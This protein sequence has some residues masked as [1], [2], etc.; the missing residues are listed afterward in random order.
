MKKNT[1]LPGQFLFDGSTR[2][3]K[4][5]DEAVESVRMVH[6]MLK[7][8]KIYGCFSGGKDSLAMKIVIRKAAEK[9]GVPLSEY[10]DFHYNITGIDPPELYRYIKQSHPDVQMHMYEESM[11]SLIARK[12]PPTR[13]H[14][15]CCAHLKERGGYGRYC[16]TG[17]RWEESNNRAK[18]RAR[19]ETLGKSKR[20]N[21]LFND[22]GEARRNFEMC[23]IKAKRIVNPIIGFTGEDVWSLIKSEREPYCCLY[24]EGFDRLGCIGCPM[25]S[26]TRYAQFERWPQFKKL[27]LRAFGKHLEYRKQR[28]LPIAPELSTPEGMFAWWMEEFTLNSQIEG[29]MFFDDEDEEGVFLL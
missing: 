7:G 3:Q 17:V 16:A 24:D 27:Y 6:D 10:A 13:L 29:Q 8:D 18:F 20:E 22:N 9:D 4:I 25:A 5:L 2:Q 12:G 26:K 28:G 19:H 23:P 11:W 14:R 21:F 15:F 1:E